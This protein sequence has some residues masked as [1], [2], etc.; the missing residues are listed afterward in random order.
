MKKVIEVK[1]DV[2][3]IDWK[4]KS[5]TKLPWNPKKFFISV[6]FGNIKFGSSGEKLSKDINNIIDNIE[7]RRPNV[8]IN[9]LMRKFDVFSNIFFISIMMNQINH[10]VSFNKYC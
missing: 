2:K 7:I 6:F 10:F 4:N 8:S 1:M 3:P 5:D 9:L